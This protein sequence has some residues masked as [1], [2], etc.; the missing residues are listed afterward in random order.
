MLPVL[1]CPIVCVACSIVTK[2]ES[3]DNVPFVVVRQD[4]LPSFLRVMLIV[5]APGAVSVGV[6][7]CIAKKGCL[8][9]SVTAFTAASASMRPAPMLLFLA[10]G[11]LDAVVS[12]ISVI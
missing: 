12:I 3:D 4:P 7:D 1:T 2:G 8:V 5:F 11:L 10:A 6:N 9:P